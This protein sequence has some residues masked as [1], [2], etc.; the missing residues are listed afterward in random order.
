M[1]DEIDIDEEDNTSAGRHAEIMQE[2]EKF[3]RMLGYVCI[4]VI[5]SILCGGL[6]FVERLFEALK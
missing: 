4:F 3:A 2:G 1:T 5:A 6:C